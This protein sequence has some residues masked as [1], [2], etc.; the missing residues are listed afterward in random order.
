[1]KS[2]LLAVPALGAMLLFSGCATTGSLSDKDRLAV[3]RSH[4]G[5]PVS[6]FRY[7]GS[8]MGWTDLGDDALALQT[9]PN[10]SWLLEFSSACPGLS[11]AMGI[12][13]TSTMNQVYTRF[14]KVLVR[15]GIPGGCPISSIRPLDTQALKAEM[16]ALRQVEAAERAAV[17][18]SPAA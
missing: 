5:Q 18:D 11:S 13:L 3:Y 6:K 8:F 1:M 10:E 4:A 16:K 15:G 14:D 9:R 17:K 12:A 7:N 2:A